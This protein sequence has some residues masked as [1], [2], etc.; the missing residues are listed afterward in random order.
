MNE[1][2]LTDTFT[3]GQGIR[4]FVRYWYWALLVGVLG[5]LIAYLVSTILAPR[6]EAAAVIAVNVDYGRTERLEEILENRVLDRV[7]ALMISD[8][9]YQQ[10]MDRLTSQAGL[11]EEWQSHEALRDHTRLDARLSR[12]ELIGIDTDP[13]V[14]AVI[15]NAWAEVV[16]ARLDEAYEHAWQAQAIQGAKFDVNCVDLLNGKEEEALWECIATGPDISPAVKEQLIQEVI[17]SH[18][19][20]PIITYEPIQSAIPPEEPV[21]WGRGLLIFAGGMAGF[22]VG[23]A[24]T[25]IL[26]PRRSIPRS[27]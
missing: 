26:P 9:T 7:W 18:G 4:R 16:L 13:A 15:A 14:A 17:A 19:I 24:I 27:I 6:Y 8:E 25:M 5:L 23:I 12:W 1:S 2:N 20:M 11:S 10:T 21:L 22:I 3:M